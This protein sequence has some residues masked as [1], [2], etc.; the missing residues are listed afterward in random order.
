VSSPYEGLAESAWQKKTEELIKKHPLSTK[1]LLEIVMGSWESIFSSKL[2]MRGFYI[3]K[4]IFPKPQIMGFLL[5]ELIPLELKNRYPKEWRGDKDSADKD[6]VCIKDTSYSIE[7]KTSSNPS[8]IY[9]NRS[10]AQKTTKGKK[11]KSGYYLAINFESFAENRPRP[12]IKLVRFGWLDSNDWI[13]QKAE[14]GQQC[15]LPTAVE[16]FKL[17][18]IF[19][20]T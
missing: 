4:D 16:K 8:H 17:L 2:G 7:V 5:H 15:R 6:I 9:G 12:K 14:T 18:E 20:L 3:G 13:G 19:K 11:D 10:F 1:E